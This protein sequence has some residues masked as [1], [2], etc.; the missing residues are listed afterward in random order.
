MKIIIIG[1]GIGGLSL[2]L[3]LHQRGLSCHVYEIAPEIK[4]L[5]VGISLLPHA[6]RE[7]AVLGLESQLRDAAIEIRQH[8]FFNRYGQFIYSEPRGNHA[9]YPYPDLGIHRG[10]LQMVL[11]K[12]TNERMGPET[13]ITN[14]RCQGVEQDSEGVT[15]SFTEMTTGNP[16]PAVRGDIVIACDGINSVVRKQF[17][18]DEKLA[19]AGI[20]MWR[21]VTRREPIFDGHTYFRVG[22][23]D[24][25]K[26]VIYPIIDNIDGQG[27][28]LINWVAEL[29]QPNM[30]M[31]DW[32]KGG[33][34]EDFFHAYKDWHFEWLNVAKLIT[35]ADQILEYPMVD[36][37]PVERWTF[38]RVTLLGDAAHPMYPRGANGGAQA[39]ID[40]RTLADLLSNISDPLEALMAYEKIRLEPTAKI[41][42]TNREYPPD[43]INIKVDEITGGLP[44]KNIHDVI[45]R[46]EL[47]RI[48]ENYKQ[49]A[50]FSRDSVRQV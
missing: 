14:H 37:D 16:L 22:S 47:E 29:R 41:V 20:N 17:Y 25:G 12:A 30:G 27:R 42:R 24:T 38:G 5:G 48:S 45:S 49:I 8:S 50:G 11:V 6:M 35:D 4:P 39:V 26:M 21:G 44:F 32:N 7:F 3:S 2:A 34:L 40:A 33:K 1:G 18:P 43:Y 36:R 9:G 31:N 13:I 10:R 46:E 15:V 19:Y 28:Q 23:I